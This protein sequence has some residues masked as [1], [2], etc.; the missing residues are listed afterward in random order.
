MADTNKELLQP[1][2][3]RQRVGE[4]FPTVE[5]PR[6]KENVEAMSWMEKIERRF[7]RTPTQVPSDVSDDSAATISQPKTQPP[8]TIG[9]T[10]KQMQDGQRLSAD[11]S[12]AWMVIWAKRQIQLL[13]RK[14]RKVLFSPENSE[15][16]ESQKNQIAG[17]PEKK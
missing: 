4:E 16:S 15:N 13:M 12:L 5:S 9:V 3:E 17:E 14:N 7:G 10:A 8:V 11:F 6:K 2:L 1:G